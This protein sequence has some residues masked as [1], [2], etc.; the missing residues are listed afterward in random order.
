[1]YIQ[2]NEAFGATP[3]TSASQSSPPPEVPSPRTYDTRGHRESYSRAYAALPAFSP[4]SARIPGMQANFAPSTCS[5]TP[6]P[7]YAAPIMYQDGAPPLQEQSSHR[8]CSKLDYSCLL[9]RVL[10][11]MTGNDGNSPSHICPYC[12]DLFT[13][14]PDSSAQEE[15]LKTVHKFDG[16]CGERFTSVCAF[17]AHLEI[18]HAVSWAEVESN[19]KSVAS[20][21]P[22]DVH[23]TSENGQ[24]NAS[25]TS[26]TFARMRINELEILAMESS[27]A[28]A[29]T[30]KRNLMKV[31][32]TTL[33]SENAD[34][35]EQSHVGED[36]EHTEPNKDEMLHQSLDFDCLPSTSTSQPSN[37]DVQLGRGKA[38]GTQRRCANCGQAGHIKTNK[39]LCPLLNG[40]QQPQTD[41]NP[42][43]FGGSDGVSIT[44]SH[45]VDCHDLAISDTNSTKVQNSA[46]SQTDGLF[47]CTFCHKQVHPKSWRRH[48]ESMHLPQVKWICQPQ[49]IPT[50]PITIAVPGAGSSDP[51]SSATIGSHCLFCG[52]WHPEPSHFE[53]CHR[54]KECADKP[55]AARAFDRKDHLVQHWK[56]FHG[57]KPDHK[58][59]EHWKVPINYRGHVWSCGFCGEQLANW[60]E[61]ALH[62][63]KHFREGLTMAAWDS[64]KGQLDSF[65]ELFR[66]FINDV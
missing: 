39:K 38:V 56:N 52:I 6:A 18:H 55:R 23:C 21:M 3:P 13:N 33:H 48:E 2:W 54:A 63:P 50:V 41:F 14:R 8:I 34:K 65:D 27:S 30:E 36:W 32:K 19:L 9:P 40:T 28:E 29:E 45:A 59:A 26:A 22:G 12:G 58:K 60:E 10:S 16:T 42:G 24:R 61:R 49:G 57:C 11:I 5:I 35:T 44:K 46:S 37:P 43:A 20:T 62:I 66:Q 47:Q 64:E 15:H 25:A 31:N 17:T 53:T 1:M 51:A 4:N 7:V